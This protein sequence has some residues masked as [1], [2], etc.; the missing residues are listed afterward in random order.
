MFRSSDTAD[1]TDVQLYQLSVRNTA[2]GRGNG[3]VLLRGVSPRGVR[4]LRSSASLLPANINFINIPLRSPLNPGSPPVSNLGMSENGFNDI[5]VHFPEYPRISGNVKECRNRPLGRGRHVEYARKHQ[6]FSSKHQE[7]SEFND[8]SELK[9][10]YS[11]AGNDFLSFSDT[12]LNFPEILNYSNAGCT[13]DL[14]TAGCTS[15]LN[16]AGCNMAVRQRWV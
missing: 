14:N 12:F 5:S 13:S 3:R 4:S 8:V 9:Q 10:A 11:L 16:T 7:M 1:N 2:L 15:D 6:L